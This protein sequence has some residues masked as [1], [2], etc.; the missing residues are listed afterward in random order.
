MQHIAMVLLVAGWLAGCGSAPAGVLQVA[1]TDLSGKPLPDAIVAVEYHGNMQ[2][3]YAQTDSRGIASVLL[4]DT[5]GDAGGTEV[6]AVHPRH[7]HRGILGVPP[8]T[9]AVIALPS[10]HDTQA[11]QHDERTPASPAYAWEK[12]RF[13]L[14]LLHSYARHVPGTDL[15]R[16][17]EEHRQVLAELQRAY[18]LPA[19]HRLVRECTALVDSMGNGGA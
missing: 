7:M 14:Q 5:L 2:H 10:L 15:T 6:T 16:A 1:V 3:A 17:A 11:Y 18:P 12:C 19:D 9:L 4:D 8:D 13:N